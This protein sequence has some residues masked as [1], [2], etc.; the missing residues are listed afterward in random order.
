[1][2]ALQ[3]PGQSMVAPE[4]RTAVEVCEMHPWT[5]VWCTMVPP[6][7]GHCQPETPPCPANGLIHTCGCR[8]GGHQRDG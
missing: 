3:E 7:C 2:T 6:V 4:A 1:M 5:C 8:A